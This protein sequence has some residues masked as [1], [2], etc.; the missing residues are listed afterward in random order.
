MHAETFVFW[1]LRR[2]VGFVFEYDSTSTHTYT[3]HFPSTITANAPSAVGSARF[4]FLYEVRQRAVE[5]SQSVLLRLSPTRA[6]VCTNDSVLWRACAFLLAGA[7]PIPSLVPAL[8]LQ[9]FP[10][11]LPERNAYH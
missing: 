9:L 7:C 2:H 3:I 5:E 6:N 10:V 4:L 8:T 1:R 11:R